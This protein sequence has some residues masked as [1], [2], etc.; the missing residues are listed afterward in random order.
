MDTLSKP[1]AH[2]G[3]ETVE[4]SETGPEKCAHIVKG[5]GTKSG[6]DLVTEARINGT[7]VTALCGYTWVPQQ[8]PERLPV[9][10]EC[11]D[12]YHMEGSLYQGGFTPKPKS[13]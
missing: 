10:Q 13:A 6:P 2:T 3:V 4:A 5:D 11:H 12:I 8:N 9:C 1:F 7:P